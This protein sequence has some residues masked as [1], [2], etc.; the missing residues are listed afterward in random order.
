MSLKDFL[1]MG[2]YAAYVWPAYALTLV[3]IVGAAWAS[4]RQH[5]RLVAQLERRARAENAA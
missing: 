2:G 5:R 4:R 3:V 1:D